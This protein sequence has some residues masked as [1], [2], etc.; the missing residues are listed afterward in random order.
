V[1]QVTLQEYA[2]VVRADAVAASLGTGPF[3]IAKSDTKPIARA[4]DCPSYD[5]CLNLVCALKWHTFSC[6]NCVLAGMKVR[7]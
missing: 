5:R 7:K 1:T 6:S 2:R 3:R 4:L